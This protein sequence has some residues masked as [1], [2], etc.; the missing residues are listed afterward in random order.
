MDRGLGGTE[1]ALTG[2]PQSELIKRTTA[3][4]KGWQR[5]NETRSV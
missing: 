2:G 4:V 1:H 3:G 5:G